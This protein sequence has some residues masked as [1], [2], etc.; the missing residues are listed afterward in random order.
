MKTVLNFKQFL[1]VINGELMKNQYPELTLTSELN[2]DSINLME[3]VLLIEEVANFNSSDDINME[4]P[5]LETLD[6][7]YQYYLDLFKA[8]NVP[9]E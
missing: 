9:A 5:V 4:F 6:D 1:E 3:L 2:F 7:A 8:Q